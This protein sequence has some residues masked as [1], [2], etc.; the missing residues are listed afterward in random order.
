MLDVPGWF[1]HTKEKKKHPFPGQ[2]R[3]RRWGQAAQVNLQDETH[4]RTL[5][6]VGPFYRGG[7]IRLT[8]EAVF[9]NLTLRVAFDSQIDCRAREFPQGIDVLL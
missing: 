9:A 4:R 5:P 2:V 7:E 6:V 8:S 3:S 1:I